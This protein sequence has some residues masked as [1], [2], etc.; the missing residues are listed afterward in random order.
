MVQLLVRPSLDRKAYR[1][2]CRFQTDPY[3]SQAR[4]EREKVRIAEMFVAD[5]HKQG[6]EHIER[7]GF[8][9]TGPYP[10]IIP[11]ALRPRQMPTARQMLSG[12][13]QGRRFRDEGVEGVQIMPQLEMS[14][15]WEYEIAGVF[16]RPAILTEIPSLHEEA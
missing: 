3:P 8:R 11:V 6:W 15:Y 7:F 9:M 2:R 5:M 13:Q 10:R 12:V 16:V 4:L 1:L 14:E